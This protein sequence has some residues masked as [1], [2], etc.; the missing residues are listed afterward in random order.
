MHASSSMSETSGQ[1]AQLEPVAFSDLPGWSGDDHAAALQCFMHSARRMAIRPYTTKALGTDAPALAAIASSLLQEAPAAGNARTFF[2][3]NFVPRRIQ[4]VTGSGF[5]TGYFEPQ[6]AASAESSDRFSYPIYRRPPDL[7]DIDDT[8][9]PQGMDPSFMFARNGSE[10][11]SEYPDRAAIERGAIA[12][13]GLELAWIES[14]VD[15]FFIHIQGS[16]RLLMQDGSVWRVAYDGKSGH[17]FTPIGAWLVTQGHLSREEVTMDS[18]RDWL[19]ADPG[20][21]RMLMDRNRSFIFFRR[22][23]QEDPDLGPVAAAG[24]ALSPGRSLA[25]DHRLHTFGSP[26]FVCVEGAVPQV[27]KWQRLM[28]AQ[29]TGSAII[30]PARGDLFIGSGAHAGHIAGAIKNRADFYVLIPR[31]RTGR[32]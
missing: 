4:P 15:G 29:D 20:R 23:D 24:V 9:R 2:E 5:V 25:V 27:G 31:S 18:I 8:S 3:Q 10:G 14:P 28:I 6:V 19:L 13:R 7:A 1:T 17:P 16:A 22:V 11:Y 30:G 21:A 12:G 26:I 32:T